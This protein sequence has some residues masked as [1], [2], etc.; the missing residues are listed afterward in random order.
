MLF[1]TIL[2]LN[3][4]ISL[5]YC[6]RSQTQRNINNTRR[7][8]RRARQVNNGRAPDTRREI[9]N[10]TSRI[11]V[12][13]NLLEVSHSLSNDEDSMVDSPQRNNSLT[14]TN[15]QAGDNSST[16]AE[17]IFNHNTTV[18]FNT[19]EL[20]PSFS[21]ELHAIANGESVTPPRRRFNCYSMLNNGVNSDPKPTNSRNLYDFDDYEQESNDTEYSE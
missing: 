7:Q 12:L 10:M 19:Y 6:D 21:R 20:R 2:A 5:S 14:N 17:V 8:E 15:I 18:D 4:N 9:E 13:A 16:E 3:Q 1:Q 11:E